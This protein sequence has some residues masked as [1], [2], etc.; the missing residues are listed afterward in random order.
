MDFQ[1]KL[2]LAIEL[3]IKVNGKERGAISM[4]AKSIGVSRHRIHKALKRNS[5][6]GAAGFEQRIDAFIVLNK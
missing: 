4:L 6:Y 2:R 1:E 3:S 5:Q